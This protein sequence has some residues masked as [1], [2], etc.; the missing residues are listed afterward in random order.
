MFDQHTKEKRKKNLNQTN[1]NEIER[2]KKNTG[3][4][5]DF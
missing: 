3:C 1:K 4:G 5:L 2:V